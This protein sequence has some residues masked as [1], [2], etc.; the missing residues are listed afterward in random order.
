[1]LIGVLATQNRAVCAPLGGRDKNRQID[2]PVQAIG[3]SVTCRM[4]GWL[5]GRRA[6]QLIAA[7][8]GWP[9]RTG[10]GR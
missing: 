8:Y 2:Q 1:M 6:V 7:G 5:P 4:H 3:M 9:E 10:H